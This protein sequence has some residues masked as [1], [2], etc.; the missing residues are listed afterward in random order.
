MFAVRILEWYIYIM[1]PILVK[2]RYHKFIIQTWKSEN[3]TP[4]QLWSIKIILN[5]QGHSTWMWWEYSISCIKVLP[6]TNEKE[7]VTEKTYKKNEKN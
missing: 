2:T 1:K 4:Q 7:F 6:R 5:A 3:V